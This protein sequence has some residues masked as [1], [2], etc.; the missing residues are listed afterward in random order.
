MGGR[1]GEDKISTQT[2]MAL[3]AAPEASA[4]RSAPCMGVV[5]KHANS[6]VKASASTNTIKNASAS[7]AIFEQNV[8]GIHSARAKAGAMTTI[9]EARRRLAASRVATALTPPALSLPQR[10]WQV[11]TSATATAT[12]TKT[13]SKGRRHNN[14]CRDQEEAGCVAR[15]CRPHPARLAV[16]MGTTAREGIG[17][18]N[19][20][21]DK[22]G[23]KDGNEH[24]EKVATK[25]MT[26]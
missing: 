4:A 3:A 20:D 26:R 1:G 8:G 24:E 21:K 22:D 5:D 18:G 10:G 25:T 23:N 15:G 2:A 7:S 11:R 12:T 17:N 6:C 16:A 14:D 19:N 13:K 9:A